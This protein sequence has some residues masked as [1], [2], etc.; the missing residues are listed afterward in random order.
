[1]VPSVGLAFGA[2]GDLVTRNFGAP[3]PG[4]TGAPSLGVSLRAGFGGVDG[5]SD[6]EKI[7]QIKYWIKAR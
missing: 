2:K 7:I 4:L 3:S 1:V 5:A 6:I